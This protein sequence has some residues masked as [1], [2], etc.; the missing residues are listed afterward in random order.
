MFYK[1]GVLETFSK[2]TG[3][4]CVR[5]YFLL[6]LINN[7]NN[8]NN[9]NKLGQIYKQISKQRFRLNKYKKESYNSKT[10]QGNI[11]TSYC[12]YAM[13]INLCT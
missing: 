6:K 4:T 11:I 1:K 7:N 5:V 2:F 9:N 8:N 13:V 10:N 12:K 3:N